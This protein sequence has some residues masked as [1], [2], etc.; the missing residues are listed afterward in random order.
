VGVAGWLLLVDRFGVRSTGPFWDVCLP[1]EDPFAERAGDGDRPRIGG[2]GGGRC[3][4]FAWPP[5]GGL[6]DGDLPNEASG[7]GG[8]FRGDD[9][10]AS[11]SRCCCCVSRERPRDRAEPRDVLDASDPAD[12]YP[13]A[14]LSDVY[15]LLMPLGFRLTRA[16]G[17]ADRCVARCCSLRWRS[18]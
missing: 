15:P 5:I 3:C 12:E 11:A 9:N 10:R 7:R 13:P 2:G 17:E 1:E 18:C 14:E 16:D 4:R 8:G 6:G